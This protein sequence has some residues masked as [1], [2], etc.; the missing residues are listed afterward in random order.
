MT[1]TGSGQPDS[2]GQPG[3]DSERS[4]QQK[5]SD[6]YASAAQEVAKQVESARASG[7]T[8]VQFSVVDL[9]SRFHIKRLHR[10]ART[11]MIRA[12][13]AVGLA[14]DPALAEA[15]LTRTI[16]VRS[17]ADADDAAR[18]GSDVRALLYRPGSTSGEPLANDSLPTLEIAAG[19]VLWIDAQPDT[20]ADELLALLKRH[21]SPDVALEVVDDILEY[22]VEPKVHTY[23]SGLRSVSFVGVEARESGRTG[24]T[25]RVGMAGELCFQ[26]VESVVGPTTIVTCWHHGRVSR[27]LDGDADSPS[28]LRDKAERAVDKAWAAA[29]GLS[30][31]DVGTQ[32]LATL[33]ESYKHAHR[34]LESWLQLWELELHKAE[35]SMET[36]TLNDLFALVNEFRRRLSAMNYARSATDDDTWFPGCDQAL[37]ETA[38]ARLDRTLNKLALLFENIRADM[39]LVTMEH[40]VRQAVSAA[41]QAEQVSKNTAIM[42]DQRIANEQFQDR[43]AKVTALLLVPTLIA[44]IFGANTELPGGGSWSGF[45]AMVVL[46]V[47]TSTAVYLFM[48]RTNRANARRL[49]GAIAA[50]ARSGLRRP[51]SRIDSG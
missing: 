16:Q 25:N 47:V 20:D 8:M 28:I 6:D 15:D 17:A 27:G 26:L 37:D 35:E 42:Q 46:M 1:S 34:R 5:S 49:L 40:V 19:E 30:P 9:M 23:E 44:G 4:G 11:A 38:D 10:D 14:A 3:S 13:E 29:G 33:T 12:L 31:A 43:L 24:A 50:E 39:E 36:R 41:Q 2:S 21:L 45:V 32:I 7:Q 51:S 22:D 18:S 48:V